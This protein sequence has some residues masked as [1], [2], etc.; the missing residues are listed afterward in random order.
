MSH[1]PPVGQSYN[2]LS[3]MWTSPDL[4]CVLQRCSA[5]WERSAGTAWTYSFAQRPWCC[6]GGNPS[7]SHLYF[8]LGRK[9][10]KLQTHQSKQTNKSWWCG[11]CSDKL[12]IFLR[13]PHLGVQTHNLHTRRAGSM[14]A[15]K[16]QK[17][18]Y[19]VPE[20][21][22]MFVVCSQSLQGLWRFKRFALW[23]LA[24]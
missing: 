16:T 12:W 13:T 19:V 18:C 1:I 24:H 4:W 6:L 7:G 11:W 10:C 14:P 17:V 8:G 20:W 5:C 22:D 3:A 15:G 23:S 9:T 2:Q 21:F